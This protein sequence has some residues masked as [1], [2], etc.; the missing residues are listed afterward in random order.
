LFCVRTGL[1]IS[2]DDIPR[3]YRRE[4]LISYKLSQI[5]FF[6]L[7]VSADMCLNKPVT[8]VF[9][10][11]LPREHR[12]SERRI[13]GP[14]PQKSLFLRKDRSSSQ[15]NTSLYIYIAELRCP[16]IFHLPSR[17]LSRRF[18]EDGSPAI[19]AEPV[20]IKEFAAQRGHSL[21]GWKLVMD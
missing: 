11:W 20:I 4:N 13:V 3:S 14:S 8:T 2:Q 16:F 17:W 18:D 9:E 7:C 19:A 6:S 12:I 10:Y 1:Y 15:P 5:V 21:Q